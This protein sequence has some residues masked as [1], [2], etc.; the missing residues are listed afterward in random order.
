M[1]TNTT[2]QVISLPQSGGALNGIGEKF[3]PDLFTGTGNFSIPIELPRGRNGFQ[4]QLSLAYSTGSGDGPFGMGWSLSIP[5]VTRKTSKGVPRYDDSKDVF[6]LS[7]SEDL[8]PVE[9]APG[10]MRYRPRTEGLFARTNHYSGETGDFWK[11]ETKDGLQSTYGRGAAEATAAPSVIVDPD[12]PNH[13]LA[14]KLTR[15]TDPFGNIIEYRYIQDGA[16]LYLSE[17]RYVDYGTAPAIQ[18]LVSVNF[19]YG[20][21][22]DILSDYRAGFEIR[23]ALRCS[24]INV[25][26]HPGADVLARTYSLLYAGDSRIPEDQAPLNGASLLRQVQVA[27][28][29]G[30]AQQLLPPLS[31]DYTKF[32]PGSQRF[33]AV[34]GPELPPNSLSHPDQELVSLFGNGLLDVLQMNGVARYWRNLGNGRFDRPRMMDT[35]PAGVQLGAEGVQLLDANGDGRM[36][37]LLSTGAI[38]GYYPLQ[39]GGMWDSHSFQRYR[40]TPS[41]SLKDPEVHMVDLDGD[42]ITDAIRSS[43]RLECFFNDP[44]EG[45]HETLS[46]ERATLEDFPNVNFSDPRVKWA[47][48]TGGGLQDIVLIHSGRVDYWPSL[49]RGRWAKRVTMAGSPALPWNYDPRRVL[50]GDV[51]GDGAA[52]II[53]VDNG[54][55]TLWINQSGKRWSAPITIS[56]TPAFTDQDSVRLVDLMG[57]GVGGIL[58]SRD[59]MTNAEQQMYFLDLTGGNKP[60]LLDQIDNHTGATTKIGYTSSTVFYLKDQQSPETRWKTPLPFPVQVVARVEV[61]DSISNTKLATEYSYHHGYWDGIEREF[62]GFGRVDHRD[63]ETFDDFHNSSLHPPS[64]E[65]QAVPP[66][67]F[68]P[69]AETRTWFHQG[70]IEDGFGDWQATDFTNE[71][72]QGDPQILGKVD[73]VPDLLKTLSRPARRDALRAQRGQVLR[74]E[75]YALDGAVRQNRPYT[76]TENLSGLREESP[77]APTQA[78]NP[79]FSPFSIASRTTQWERGDDPMTQFTFTGDYDKYGQPRV[80]VSMAV[81][82]GRDFRAGVA[83]DAAFEPYLVTQTKTD[84]A[85]RDDATLYMTDRVARVTNYEIRNDGRALATDVSLPLL[86]LA[87]DI[88]GSKVQ[89]E[90]IGQTLQFYDGPAFAGLPFGQLGNYGALTR[91]EQLTLTDAILNAA[92]GDL[93]SGVPPYFSAGGTPK[94]TNEYP[95]EFQM[96][97]PPSAGYLYRGLEAGSPFQKGYFAVSASRRYDFQDNPAGQGRGLLASQRDPLGHEAFISY[98]APYSLLPTQVKDAAGLVTQAEYDYRLLKPHR[99]TD[100]NGN[101]TAYAYTPLG[102]LSSIAVMGKVTETNG[103]TEAVPGTTLTYNFST[104]PI[105]AR[106]EKR[107][108]HVNDTNAPPE[109]RDQTIVTVEYSDGFGR[110]VQTRSRAEDL[111]FGDPLF[112]DGIVPANQNSANTSADVA[113]RQN[114]DSLNPNVIVSG[115]QLYDNKGKVIRKFEPFY[116]LG[117][118]YIAPTGAQLGRSFTLFYDPRG[119]LTRTLNPDGSEQRVVFG[120]PGTLA[121]S[122]LSNPDV[123]E[124]TPWESYSYDANDNAGRTHAS[125]SGSYQNHWNTPASAV[126]DALGRVTESTQRNGPNP[127]TDWFTTRSRYDIRGNVLEIRDQL[128]RTAF[129][130]IYDLANHPLRTQSLDAGLRNITLDAAGSEIERRDSKGALILHSYDVLNRPLRM[131]AR[132]AQARKMTLRQAFV[133]GDQKDSGLASP[134]AANLLGKAF[135]TY[136]EAGLATVEKYDFKGNPVEALR[137]VIS[138]AAILAALSPPVTGAGQPSGALPFIVDWQPAPDVTL[139]ARASVLLDAASYRTSTTYDALNRIQTLLYPQ[140]A[141]AKRSQLRPRYNQAGALEHVELDGTVYVDQIAYNCKGQ[142]TLVAYGNGALSRYAYDPGTFRLLRLRTEGYSKPA[143]SSY[144]PSGTVL[145]DF[146]YTYD[147]AGNILQITDRTPGSGVLNNP[148]SVQV[149]D[150]DLAGLL[151]SGDA[152]I[153]HFSYDPIYRLLSASGRECSDIPSPR[154]WTDDQRRGFNSPQQ[155][156]PNQDNAPMQTAIYREDYSYDPAGNMVSLK[157]AGK[158]AAWVRSSGMGGMTPQQW[159]VEWPRHLGVGPWPAPLPNSL[160][161]VGDN[162]PV[163]SQTH[164]YDVNGNL[165]R[166]TTSRNFQ[167]D[168]S[169]RLQAYST[170]AP[171]AAASLSAQYLYDSAGQRVKKLVRKQGGKIEGTVYIG[172]IFEQEFWG[173]D[174]GIQQSSHIHVLDNQQRIAIVR[175]GQAHP[176]DKGPAVQFHFG[177]HL[178]SVSIVADDTGKFINREEYTPYGETIFGSFARKRYRFTGKGRDGESGLNYH[179]ARYYAPWIA[180]WVSCDPAGTVDGLNLFVYALQNPVKYTDGNGLSVGQDLATGSQTLVDTNKQFSEA[181]GNRI[182]DNMNDSLN[183]LGISRTGLSGST[184]TLEP[185]PTSDEP[186]LFAQAADYVKESD[187]VQFALGLGGGGLAGAAPGG[188]IVGIFGE[189]TGI[190][191]E[192]PRAYRLGYGLGE[193]AWGIAQ[194]IVGGAGEVGSGALV[195]GGAGA[196]ATG[197]GALAGAPAIA[198]GVGAISVSTAVV[199]EGA[200]DVAIGASVFM[201]A[202]GESGG[203]GGTRRITNPK[204]HAGSQSP[205]PRNAQELFDRAIEDR[206]GVRWARDADGTIHRFSAPSNGESHWNGSTAGARPI[207]MEDIPIEVRRAYR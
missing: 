28:I 60:Y 53:Y 10:R 198:G 1:G 141:T 146:A 36:D 79:I 51:D 8:V 197:V 14:W 61:F 88:L 207:R 34:T 172:G 131:W 62:R 17:I 123:F 191:R 78:R 168:H 104:L 203:G 179:G 21:R 19:V 147:L 160:T 126:I 188:G 5:G 177:D 26:T 120:V 122:E 73:P 47:D 58:W 13:I 118:Q 195:V 16:Q 171:G 92:Y 49:G 39:F 77:P 7:G 20:P 161:H 25:F 75:F 113:G 35:A 31:L 169:D 23:T 176:D 138:N 40:V 189:A 3:S 93:P 134:Q 180:R 162:N 114:T 27:G 205:E 95:P 11:I 153:R 201:S 183:R 143:A 135:Q 149:T 108:Y 187:T 139:A 124:P 71:F 163:V 76:V 99:V 33:F 90:V 18:F 102:L 63:T 37:L 148:E 202:L 94:W 65:A 150:P 107:I 136:D 144:H 196:S 206:N 155:G 164:F 80:Q 184:A 83:A 84:Y 57:N 66:E 81:P 86:E 22:P 175:A 159:A 106:T 6:I 133:Y 89:G 55:I 151:V 185:E 67:F 199:V 48:M 111:L 174:K 157:H 32:A 64:R 30:S 110:V 43:A 165:V 15:T 12:H 24:S 103:D 137:L 192:L 156:T 204:H 4:P 109:V 72:W 128:G 130:S 129:Q 154:P 200:A 127:A 97:L 115:W 167:W 173:D 112:G 42:G 117:W 85:Q 101:R 119:E 98:D 186:S 91:S 100:P 178:G 70:P 69:P 29:D 52:D 142:R 74:T 158:S 190:S 56:G 132:D 2:S 116:S 46:I 38:S 193:A 152:L 170:Q 41:F 140:D 50:I 9:M 182:V 181:V 96:L 145:Q 45:W 105:S 125:T 44:I 121:N 68:S 166:E 54:S 87:Q 194:I 82:R 59:A